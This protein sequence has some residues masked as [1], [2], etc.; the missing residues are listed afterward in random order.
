MHTYQVPYVG[1]LPQSFSHVSISLLQ[2]S[3]DA[4]VTVMQL[5]YR[6]G[7]WDGK[8]LNAFFS[9]SLGWREVVFAPKSMHLKWGWSL[10][11]NPA[12]G[13]WTHALNPTGHADLVNSSTGV[14]M[15]S[16]MKEKMQSLVLIHHIGVSPRNWHS[17]SE[18]KVRV[19]QGEMEREAAVACRLLSQCKD[20]VRVTE[21][22]QPRPSCL[23]ALW[24]PWGL[25][26]L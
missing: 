13:I 11:P 14:I 4:A 7:N 20:S 17:G 19:H 5:F 6:P 21:R 22:T 15:I 2:P 10:L 18:D 12:S 3:F 9:R 24:P 8:E 25:S 16:G 23:H 26:Y 1:H